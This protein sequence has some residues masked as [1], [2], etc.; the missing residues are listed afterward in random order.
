MKKVFVF[1]S[2][3]RGNCTPNQK[4]ACFLL[5]L[6]IINTFLKKYMYLNSKLSKELKNNIKL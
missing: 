2:S 5:Y 4:I 6:K 1:L 3:L